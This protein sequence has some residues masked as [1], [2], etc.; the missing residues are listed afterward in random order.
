MPEEHRPAPT[1]LPLFAARPEANRPAARALA[2]TT[3]PPGSTTPGNPFVPPAPPVPV[4]QPRSPEPVT[5]AG[6]AEP[7]VDWGTVTELRA[8][9]SERIRGILEP[10]AALDAAVHGQDAQRLIEDA[11]RS[12]NLRQ[13]SLGRPAVGVA[14]QAGLAKAVF[15]AIFGF[16]RIEPLLAQPGLEN[17]EIRGYDQVVCL[18]GDGRIEYGGP[19]A[20]SNDQLVREVQLQAAHGRGGERSFSATAPLLDLALPD[21]SRLSATGWVGPYPMVTIRKHG[22]V[23]ID[24]YDLVDLNSLD[25]VAAQFLEAAMLAGRSAVVSGLPAAG[26]TTFMRGLLN[27]LDPDVAIATIETEFE[28]LLHRMPERHRRVWPVEARAGGGERDSRGDVIGEVTLRELVRHSLRQNVDRIVVGEVRGEEVLDMLDAMTAGQGS[29]STIHATG[30]QETIERMVTCALKAGAQV[31]TDYAYRQVATHIDLIVNLGVI[32]QTTRG[33]RKHR[34][35]RA[36]SAVSLGDQQGTGLSLTSVFAPGPD[37]RAVPTGM[38]PDWIEEL[39]EFGFD[40]NLLTNRVSQ[41][42]APLDLL[43]PAPVRYGRRRTA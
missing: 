27:C 9:V 17:I 3:P 30:V 5:R 22:L 12:H 7:R 15:D 8:E 20:D 31:T 35:L 36:V 23:D 18:F 38:L 39:R 1:D 19:V 33:G 28:L 14:E 11:V 34:F 24:L 21:G 2:G 43:P 6:A 10:G 4:P 29:L 40:P 16:G 26:K 13:L 41:Y 25:E 37:G 32:D 42:R